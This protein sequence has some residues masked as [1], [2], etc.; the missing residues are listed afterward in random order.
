[1]R[2]ARGAGCL[3]ALGCLKEKFSETGLPVSRILG[4]S[5]DYEGIERAGAK[6]SRQ[7]WCT[8]HDRRRVLYRLRSHVL[9]DVVALPSSIHL[10]CPGAKILGE[11]VAK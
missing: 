7:G 2:V 5:E 1:V 10:A 8:P 4:N 3:Y 11:R 9:L 6:R